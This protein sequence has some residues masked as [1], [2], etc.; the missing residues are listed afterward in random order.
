MIINW[1]SGSLGE[2]RLGWVAGSCLWLAVDTCVHGYCCC[3]IMGVSLF[4]LDV[5]GSGGDGSISRN[6]ILAYGRAERGMFAPRISVD[7]Q[8]RRG[9][10]PGLTPWGAARV[11]RGRR[12]SVMRDRVCI[13]KKQK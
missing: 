1:K 5:C 13:L 11:V 6:N 12:R 7:L 4:I 3:D 10:T 9:L 8:S 2:R